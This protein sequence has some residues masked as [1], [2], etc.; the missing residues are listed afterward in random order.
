MT[1]E[2][3][4]RAIQISSDMN[5]IYALQDTLA[6]SKNSR[7]IA[8]IEVKKFDAQRISIEECEVLNHARIPA[9]IMEKFEKILWEELDRLKAEF[10]RL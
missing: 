10:N 7:F 9:N 3:F 1:Q 4:D 5:E 6:N 2:Q 8:A